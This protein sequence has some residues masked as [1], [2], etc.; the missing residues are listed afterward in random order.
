MLS[1]KYRHL[2]H[3]ETEVVGER[4]QKHEYGK[5]QTHDHGE[6]FPELEKWIFLFEGSLCDF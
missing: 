6:Q 5:Q 3:G 1:L 2:S 4:R